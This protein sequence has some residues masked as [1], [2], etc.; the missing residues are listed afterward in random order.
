MKFSDVPRFFYLFR[1]LSKKNYRLGAVRCLAIQA[2]SRWWRVSV[3]QVLLEP[4]II[5]PSSGI[6]WGT[7][8]AAFDDG[9]IEA[10]GIHVVA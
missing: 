2:T 5:G 10:N 1:I 6:G 8:M 7:T 9:D 4:I 3:C